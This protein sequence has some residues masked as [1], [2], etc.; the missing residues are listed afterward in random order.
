MSEVKVME[1]SV[2]RPSQEAGGGGGGCVSQEDAE[3]AEELKLQANEC[4]K[5]IVTQIT[6]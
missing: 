1:S 4:F 5:G 6:H 2:D 3:K